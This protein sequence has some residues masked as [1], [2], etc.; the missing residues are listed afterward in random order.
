MILGNTGRVFQKPGPCCQSRACFSGFH[1]CCAKSNVTRHAF[2][3]SLCLTR[4]ALCC[5]LDM[6]HLVITASNNLLCSTTTAQTDSNPKEQA[7]LFLTAPYQ[8]SCTT[9]APL[10]L[11]KGSLAPIHCCS[12][13]NTRSS[14]LSSVY[15]G[16]R[17]L[18]HTLPVPRLA[19]P[20]R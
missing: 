14:V 8:S 17:Y 16:F 11:S 18:A 19:P 6:L 13:F 4:S 20:S 1:K 12:A 5:A 3:Y 10:L 2:R 15:T 7:H 9:L